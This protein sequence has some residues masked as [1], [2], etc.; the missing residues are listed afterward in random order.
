VAATTA[1]TWPTLLGGTETIGVSRNFAESADP[2]AEERRV[3][4]KTETNW[5]SQLRTSWLA[6]KLEAEESPFRG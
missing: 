3:A 4:S 5:L 2:V 1:T 6:L